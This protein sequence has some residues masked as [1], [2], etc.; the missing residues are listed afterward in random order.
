[1]KTGTI[2]FYSTSKGYG[3]IT[4]S[5]D[6]KEYF[7]HISGVIGAIPDKGERVQFSLMETKKGMQAEQ[8]LVL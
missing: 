3:F 6:A 4:D 8:V 7:F 2:K 5:L 1:M